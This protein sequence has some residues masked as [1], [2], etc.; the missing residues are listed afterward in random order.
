M[1]LVRREDSSREKKIEND[2]EC[3]GKNEKK[4][5]DDDGLSMKNYDAMENHTTTLFE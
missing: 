3:F 2:R 5:I 1:R 4:K